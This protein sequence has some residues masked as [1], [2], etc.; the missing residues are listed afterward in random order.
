MTKLVNI[1]DKIEDAGL[2]GRG[3]A[4]FSVAKKWAAVKM[5]LKTKKVAYIIINGAE[6]EPG[7]KKDEHVLKYFSEDLING[8]SLAD[9]YFGSEKVQR[10]YFFLNSEYF[11]KYSPMLKN[12]LSTKK[13]SALEKKLKFIVK[14]ETLRYI[15]G[16]ESAI[17]NIIEGKK[18]EPRLKPPYPTNE[19]LFSAP[20]LINNVETFY[21]ISLVNSGRFKNKRFYT[22]IGAVRHRGVFSLPAELSIEEVLKKT[23]N[24]PDF[25]F[26]VQCGGEA[27]GEILR[28]DQLNRPVEG[29]GSIMVYDFQKTDKQKLL[30]YWLNFY[31]EQ[32]CGNCTICR[33]G[34]YRLW[35][36]INK[37][38]FDKK[39]FWELISGLEETSFCAL[40]RSLP[41]PIKSYYS[42]I[43]QAKF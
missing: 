16:E 39:L 4:S 42:N 2:V 38:N 26:F 36:L 28:S 9:K 33:E 3:G 41:I 30:K 7:V 13:Y 31:Y 37:K 21:N 18:I 17:I 10:I 12:I 19:G 20:T 29:A 14:G 40:G 35:E 34:T 1:I 15:S 23:N 5:A 11:K 25:K 43:L 8:I 24:I 22:L 27:S 6:G 32:S